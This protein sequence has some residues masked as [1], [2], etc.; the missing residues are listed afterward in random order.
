MKEFHYSLL[1]DMKSAQAS[2][3]GDREAAILPTWT[4]VDC[5][6]VKTSR[7]LWSYM[8]DEG[9]NVDVSSILSN[10]T[11]LAD[12]SVVPPVRLDV[13]VYHHSLLTVYSMPISPDRP[14]EVIDRLMR[15]IYIPL[16][17]GDSGQLSRRLR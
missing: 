3:S 4:H 7:E 16:I 12:L 6:N 8:K 15:E 2:E 13:T 9:W 5:S 17:N 10:Q 1:L 11:L 14:I